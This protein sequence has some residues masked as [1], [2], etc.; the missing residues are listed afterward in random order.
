[1]A[2]L[3]VRLKLRLVANGL[4]GNPGRVAVLVLGTV[5]AL[6]A[7][8][9]GYAL[10][11]TAPSLAGPALAVVVV[12][13]IFV[14]WCV[15]PVVAF[16]SDETLDPARLAVLPLRHRQL[17]VGLTA[18]SVVGLPALATAIALTG[19]IPGYTSPGNVAGALLVLVDAAVIVLM[20]V[21][22]SRA[23]AT[24][25][26]GL[27][28][29]RRGRDLSVL[30]ISLL[31]VG[32]WGLRVLLAH[33]ATSLGHHSFD[34]SGS[35]LRWLPPGMAGQAFI[36]VRDGRL[37]AALAEVAGAAA[38]VVVLL[39][40]WSHSLGRALTNVAS[41]VASR[42]DPHPTRIAL[43]PVLVS[44]LL[45]R[46][47]TGAVAAKELRYVWRN[48]GQRARLVTNAAIGA[49]VPFSIGALRGGTH[50]YG[51]LLIVLTAVLIAL[52]ALNCFGFDGTAMWI[53]VSAGADIGSNLAG[54]NLALALLASPF[55]VVVAVAMAGVGQHW[56]DLPLVIGLGL[57]AL[58][59]TI[60]VGNLTSVRAPVVFP[61]LGTNAFASRSG[62]GCAV[63][64]V[65]LSALCAIAL[66]MAPMVGL[67]AAG[68]AGWEPGVV[69]AVP[70]ALGYGGA[71]CVGGRMLARS[72]LAGREPELL[73]AL[74]PRQAV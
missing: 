20:C 47:S 41:S 70:F 45:P 37:L 49:F 3:F 48:P 21:V 64:L 13:V 61:D 53:D 24:A 44:R 65:Q 12:T 11:S 42:R 25:L 40:W 23:V 73:A 54:R 72:W 74:A 39:A 4:R 43:F 17:M 36:D 63:G 67:A 55:L 52:T 32:Y 2:G 7:G 29:S 15:L 14:G 9:T 56:G 31:G 51:S 59:V 35:V 62:Q 68:L 71:V 1:M 58:G 26:S 60:G 69:L 8:F 66:L 57:G 18:S 28:R 19:A 5:A 16:G 38:F 46:N 6:L 50:D 22:G 33:T 30:L 34:S 10:L 27:L